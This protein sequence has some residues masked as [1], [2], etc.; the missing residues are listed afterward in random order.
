MFLRN[1]GLVV[2]GETIE[3]AFA[4]ACNVV[5]ACEAQI[6]MMPVGLDNLVLVSDE[7]K[8]RSLEVAKRAN[9]FTN[10]GKNQVRLA[11]ADQTDHSLSESAAEEPKE[12]KPRTREVKWRHGDME[13]EA[14]MRMLDNA[15]LAA[16]ESAVLRSVDRFFLR[17]DTAPGTRTA[18]TR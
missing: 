8:K 10:A 13:F 3:E 11:P 14:Y 6:R 17:R 12:L 4:R 1:H 15:V 18:C 5:L 9:E 7:A 16:V 2:L